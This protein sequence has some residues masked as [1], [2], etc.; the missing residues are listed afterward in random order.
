MKGI[1]FKKKV[2]NLVMPCLD[3]AQRGIASQKMNA[4]MLVLKDILD[5][6]EVGVKKGRK[7]LA[8]HNSMIFIS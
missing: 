7:N 4:I 1:S 5:A 3:A 6:E 8:H 2:F